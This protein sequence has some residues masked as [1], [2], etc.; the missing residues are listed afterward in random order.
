MK[1]VLKLDNQLCF[2][3]YSTNRLMTKMYQPYL[4]EVNLTYPQYLVMLV[5]LEQEAITVK[6]L[7]EK[8]F[9]DSGTLTPL[10][11][12]MANNGLVNRTRASDDE[13]KVIITLTE[14][15]RAIEKNLE[16]IPQAI[17][18]AYDMNVEEMVTLRDQLNKLRGI[19]NT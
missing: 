9:L 6:G 10:L 8:L 17:C 19:L 16:V 5:M 4:K 12:R 2:A 13:R 1:E 3:L 7:G 11:K 14:K 15:G 18:Q